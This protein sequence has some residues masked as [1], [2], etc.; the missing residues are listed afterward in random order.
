MRSNSIGEGGERLK[1]REQNDGQGTVPLKS[2]KV[3]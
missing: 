3:A 1:M 2:G